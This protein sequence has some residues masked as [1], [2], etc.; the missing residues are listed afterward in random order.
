MGLTGGAAYQI[1]PNSPVSIRFGLDL[2]FSN[3]SVATGKGE[4]YD[5]LRGRIDNGVG[6]QLRGSVVIVYRSNWDVEPYVGFDYLLIQ[7]AQMPMV[8]LG[9][10][11][12]L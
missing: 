2:G 4:P 7:N 12:S 3:V 1:L 6:L 11:G 8:M 10:R 9:L 5:V